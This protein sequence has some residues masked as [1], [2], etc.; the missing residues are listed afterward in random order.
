MFNEKTIEEL[1]DKVVLVTGAAGSIGSEICSQLTNF[2]IQLLVALDQWETGLFDLE[3]EFKNCIPN[4]NIKVA[5]ASVRDQQRINSITESYK[6][7]VVF[8]AAAYKFD[9]G[10]PMRIVNLAHQGELIS[11]SASGDNSLIQY[12]IKVLVP[13]L[14]NTNSENESLIRNSK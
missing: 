6:P 7:F 8:H 11:A 12:L 3:N 14:N 10:E 1:K 5:L 2:P 13:E 4:T 9:M